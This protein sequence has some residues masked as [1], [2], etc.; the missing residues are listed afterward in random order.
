MTV[1]GKKIVL[2][3]TLLVGLVF[4]VKPRLALADECD[5][6]PNDQSHIQE[7]ITCLS[8]KVSQLSTQ[9][10]TLKNQIS[11]FDYQ[12][13]L[14][15]LRVQD[16]EE[17]IAQL[18]GRIGQLEDSLTVLSKAFSERAVETYKMSRLEESFTFLFTAPGLDE[19]VSRFHYLQRVQEAD[20][21]LLEKLETAQTSYEG[22]KA[23]Q[24]EL[25]AELKK[26]QANL[27]AQK[28]AKAALLSA[29]KNDEQKY[30]SLLS[31]A[32]AEYAAIQAIIAG[33]GTETQAGH[34]NEGQRIATIIQGPSCNSSAAHLHFI[35]RKSGGV[36]DNP[37]S[38]L[39]SGISFDNCS[40]SSCGSSDG[41]SFN[42]SGS[43]V[44][45]ISSKI[46][47]TQGYGSTWAVRN[48][49]V[50]K[51]YSFHNGI[52]INS[53]SS[54]EIKAVKAGTLYQGSYNVGCPL[55]Y[56]RVDHDDSDLDTMYLHVNY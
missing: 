35:V 53:D 20:R 1:N 16:A 21:E 11:Q 25:Q 23:D 27:N 52:D 51:I 48:T 45:P 33:K 44:W 18:G 10:S 6:I 19:A 43:W 31:Q 41:D 46:K 7:K 2:L 56:V 42:P 40:G 39:A 4:F 24:E 26:Q 28:A 55:R 9:A 54:S 22:Q 13:R 32:R 8:N 49:W 12:I 5:N 15:S 37:F 38:Y 50:G 3:F 14:T 47:F 34:V 36:T 29:T 30:Q 17:K